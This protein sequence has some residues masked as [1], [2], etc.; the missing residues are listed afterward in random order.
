MC[1]QEVVTQYFK[2]LLNEGYVITLCSRSDIQ[3][4]KNDFLIDILYDP[5]GY[6]IS[7]QFSLKSTDAVLTLQ[8]LNKYFGLNRVASYQIPKSESMPKAVQYTAETVRKILNCF[9]D[10]EHHLIPLIYK[11]SI[12]ERNR[13]LNQ[14]YIRIELDQAQHYFING[15]FE[16]A[17]E[18]YRRQFKSLSDTEKKKL[19]YI[20]S[21]LIKKSPV[22][23]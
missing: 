13:Q 3:Y 23:K 19:Q 15:E 17:K 8:E 14:Y 2:F 10:N 7:A 1:F 12:N 20:E 18:I 6:E 22:E 5:I 11:D 21:H 9:G 16:K 4:A